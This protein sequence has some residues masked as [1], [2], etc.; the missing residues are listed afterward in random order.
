MD[1]PGRMNSDSG[2]KLRGVNSNPTVLHCAQGFTASVR[3]III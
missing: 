3:K 2:S 1:G